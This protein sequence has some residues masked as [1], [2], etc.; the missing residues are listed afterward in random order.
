MGVRR[1]V[2]LCQHPELDRVPIIRDGKLAGL[3]CT[4]CGTTVYV[5]ESLFGFAWRELKR[6][7]RRG[8]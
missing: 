3:Q 1:R 8:R 7:L 4:L 5:G 6:H 2:K